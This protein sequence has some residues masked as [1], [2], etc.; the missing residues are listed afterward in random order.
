MSKSLRG[1]F[2]LSRWEKGYYALAKYYE[3]M[4]ET[5]QRQEQEKAKDVDGGAGS[6]AKES[7]KE[8]EYLGHII[9]QYFRCLT[10]GSTYIFQALP[11]SLTLWM[12]YGAKVSD[13]GGTLFKKQQGVLPHVNS[14]VKKYIDSLPEYQLLTA[15]PQLCS[16]ICHQNSSVFA[17]IEA[18]MIKLLDKY[19]Q[20]TLWMMIAV[21]KSAHHMRRTR[22]LEV[23]KKARRRKTKLG[24]LMVCFNDLADQLIDVCNRQ[25]K[26]KVSGELRLQRD[27]RDLE[28]ML[29]PGEKSIQNVMIPVTAALNVTLPGPNENQVSQPFVARG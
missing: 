25:I 24:Q 1:L 28:K 8:A 2:C 12:D 19:E 11:R 29:R 17:L 20:Q 18:I 21:S 15:L 26:G 16:R 14:I 5:D 23:F 22:C 7:K 27:F 4:L 10:H 6:T 9:E 13:G 3:D